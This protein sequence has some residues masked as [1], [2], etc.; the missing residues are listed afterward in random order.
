MR[1]LR[2]KLAGLKQR[3]AK[4]RDAVG[5]QRELILRL[6]KEQRDTSVAEELLDAMTETLRV[7]DDAESCF[8]DE[9]KSVASEEWRLNYAERLEA[10]AANKGNK[11]LNLLPFTDL[12]LMQPF[13]ERV[14]LKC[15]SRLRLQVATR[16]MKT[17]HFP[18][19]GMISLP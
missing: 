14:G 11:L 7:Y 4:A 10:P 5:R 16:I 12:T 18:E 19:S 6:E 15:H 9:L 17:V 1:D 3:S 13:L 8:I 2:E